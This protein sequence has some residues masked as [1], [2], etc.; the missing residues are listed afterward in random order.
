[1]IKEVLGAIAMA[2]GF[3]SLVFAVIMSPLCLFFS[4][5][6]MLAAPAAA[7]LFVLFFFWRHMD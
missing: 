5:A 7:F 1:L 2:W 3:W 4:P 6:V